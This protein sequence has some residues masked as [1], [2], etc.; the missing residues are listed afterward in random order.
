MMPLA[1]DGQQRTDELKAKP[2][3]YVV[4]ETFMTVKERFRVWG[5]TNQ[6]R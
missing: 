4:D 3:S 5:S 1:S 6:V 2:L